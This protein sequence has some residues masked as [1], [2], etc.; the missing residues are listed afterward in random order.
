MKY[1]A[2]LHIHSRFSR[3]TA[4][5]L[6]FPHLYMA[7]RQ[8][9]ITVVATGDFTHP[10]WLEEIR[11]YLEPAEPGLLKLKA[12]FAGECEKQIAVAGN[13]PVRFMLCTEISNIYKKNS[14]TRKLH[15]L[16][17]FPE[18]S[19]VETFNSRLSAIGN[20]KSDG[21]PILGLDSKNLLEIMLETH[22]S[23]FL[24][25]AHIWTPWFSL[26]GSKSGFDSVAECFEDL[27]G[28]IF[29][30]ETGLSSDP[31][32][33][34]RVADLDNRTLI[35]NS[36]A[37]SPANLGREANLFDTDLSYYAIRNA[38]ETG[39][40]DNFLGTL[41][42]FPEE[43]K[44]HQDGHRKCGVNLHPRQTI[45]NGGICPVC[46]APVTVGV[47][48]RVEEL[49][50]RK[51]GEKPERTHPF[52]SLIPL[53][54]ILS[55]LIGVGPKSK[56]VT[57]ALQTVISQ[58]GPELPVLH[59]MPVDILKNSGNRLLAEAI[60]RMRKGLVYRQPGFDGQYGRVTIFSPEERERL[61]GQ[62]ALFDI[63]AAAPRKKKPPRSTPKTNPTAAKPLSSSCDSKKTTQ[64]SG[65]NPILAG[66]NPAQQKAVTHGG[67]PLL[68]AAGPGTGKTR[69][70]TCRIAWLM[71]T[72][73]ALAKQ[74]LA[75]TFTHKAAGQMQ[76][77]LAAMLGPD[78]ALP[79]AR[80]FHAFCFSLLKELQKAPDHAIADEQER[81]ALIKE[82]ADLVREQGMDVAEKPDIFLDQIS[83]AKQRVLSPEDDLKSIA[84]HEDTS[85]LCAVYGKYQDLLETQH[86]WDYEDLICR[87]I[88]HLDSEPARCLTLQRR[89]PFVFID[90]YQ[91][92]NYAQYRLVRQL[93]PE[94]GQ[95]CVIG[96]PDQSI[97][98]FRGS[99]PSYFRQFARDF[100]D[101]E[102]INLKQ[103]YR[104][105]ETI[106]SAASQILPA[107]GSDG[108]LG[109]IFS[110]IEGTGHVHLI[111]AASERAEAVAAGKII[112]QMVG[113]M[114]FD[115]HDFDKSKQFCRDLRERSFSDFAVLFRT[116]AQ[117][118]LFAEIFGNAGIPCQMASK[119]SVWGI[120]GVAEHISALKI[121]EGLGSGRDMERLIGTLEP[122]FSKKD[123]A[124]VK[125][126]AR[127]RKL[128]VNGLLAEA[129]RTGISELDP[130]AAFR[131][132]NFL[133]QMAALEK[134]AAGPEVSKKLEQI[135]NILE[136]SLPEPGQTQT[137]T[138]KELKQLADGFGADAPGFIETLALRSDP[139]FCRD[140]EKVSL[141]TLHAAKGLEFPVVFIAGCE[142][143]LIPFKGT[144]RQSTDLDEERRLFYVGIT[145]AMS[146][147]FLTS[148][149]TRRI[150]GKTRHQEPSQFI[151]QIANQLKKEI[152]VG[153]ESKKNKQL[154]L[155]LFSD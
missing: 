48:Y 108:E 127:S 9:G 54:E 16:V 75:V 93:C 43:G 14:I 153:R 21:R 149:R 104:S 60:E 136:K 103:N 121:I 41:E 31:P 65:E 148:S 99:D 155:R 107:K 7:A 122:D 23:G 151:A 12:D 94:D 47:L 143:G 133:D 13:N 82:A 49:A 28:N 4:R 146:E 59:D 32:M 68:I 102:I 63:P 1:I 110:G 137:E 36:D 26:F 100:P 87:T 38:L 3:A 58:I 33:N 19:H 86:L 96:D 98:G 144:A 35:S 132:N 11:E 61:T 113:G 135:I 27:S 114:G 101:A 90:E 74:I 25:P 81:L 8:K 15:H 22:E 64:V 138:I 150:Y 29:A 69:T 128:S 20:L 111:N 130:V 51:E 84:G 17:F 134:A 115:F 45:E 73:A 46:R 140:I 24:V 40:A 131:L 78:A 83:A 85:V 5:N 42:F 70:L 56:K 105:T 120:A 39:N 147:L 119:A 18:L 62:Q 116:R 6:D 79:V 76:Q 124:A 53:A 57:H 44:Y 109:R 71:Q 37:H 141:L 91:D 154:Q 89:Y 88:M 145:R 123:F 55:E 50:G 118:E 92:L 67:G 125:A 142:D 106:L 112:E 30:V 66:L 97:Y 10:R 34:W 52:Y 139:D 129:H 126:W 152:S 80:T 2:D 117:G 95:I 72:K 77:R